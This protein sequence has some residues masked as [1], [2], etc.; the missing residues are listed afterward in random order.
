M[1]QTQSTPSILSRLSAHY[2]KLLELESLFD[3]IA[4]L[5]NEVRD[6]RT[7][8]FGDDQPAAQP[9]MLPAPV[10][11][12]TLVDSNGKRTMSDAAKKAV[13]EGVK[14]AFAAKKAAR[15]AAEAAATK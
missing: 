3:E 14:R 11:V 1:N 2:E 13:S 5:R 8:V 12:G 9:A 15:L 6:L 7:Q 4:E 10:Q